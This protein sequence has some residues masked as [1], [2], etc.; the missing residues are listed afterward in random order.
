MHSLNIF[1]YERYLL[2]IAHPD[3]EINCSALLKH[4]LDHGK[5]LKILLITD[6]DAGINASGR[7]KEMVESITAIGIKEEDLIRLSVS[8]KE[9]LAKTPDVLKEA[10]SVA[11]DYKADCIL[12]LDYEG[13][14]EGHDMSCFIAHKIA[15]SLGA[16]HIV[17]PDYHFRDMHRHGQEFLPGRSVDYTIEL[18]DDDKDLK[19]AVVDAHRGQIGFHLRMQKYQS[20][21]FSLLLSREVYRI[22]PETYDFFTRPSYQIGYEYHRNGFKFSDFTEAIKDIN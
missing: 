10:L 2:I 16:P 13:G 8:E 22:F 3:D 12:G 4:L 18:S 19:I 20:N 21:Y 9:L 6:G 1:N 14:H 5:K 7:D 15:Q 17:Y 11:L